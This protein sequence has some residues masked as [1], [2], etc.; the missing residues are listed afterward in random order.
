V[1]NLTLENVSI[2]SVGSSYIGCLAGKNQGTI[3]NCHTSG[4]ISGNEAVG[5]LV[6]TMPG[7]GGTVTNCSAAV[8][9]TSNY[10]RVGGLV[11]NCEGGTVSN[12]HAT[13]DVT[14]IAGSTGRADSGGL[15]GRAVT[16][17]H[18]TNCYAT[19]NVTNGGGTTA[20]YT[21]GLVGVFGGT[22][23]T[24]TLAN[25]YATGAVSGKYQVG[26][27][28]GS[29][30]GQPVTNCYATG[31]VTGTAQVGGLVGYFKGEHGSYDKCYST[32]NVSG[33]SYVGG[34]IGN[35][36]SV[37]A[38]SNCFWDKETSGQLISSGGT[39]KTTAQMK[40]QSTFTSAGWD[41][42]NNWFM[43]EGLSYPR[44]QCQSFASGDINLD[45]VINKIDISLLASDWLKS[46]TGLWTDIHVDNTVN[47][48]DFGKMASQWISE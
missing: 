14:V 29:T 16:G 24:C 39:A 44:L 31:T 46:G 23:N 7:S 8:S 12:S 20:D 3:T 5:G 1:S 40:T 21:G 36:T 33:T 25:S 45:G 30:D 18:I 28:T 19:G 26:G 15:I 32:S 27:L 42:N 13:G 9:V 17:T 2:V 22:I 43:R 35:K 34:L 11:G 48:L 6:G 47:F 10:R 38:V 4:T 41:F 37:V